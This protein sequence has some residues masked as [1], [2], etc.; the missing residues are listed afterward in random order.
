MICEWDFYRARYNNHALLRIPK[1]VY[2]LVL[3]RVPVALLVLE[4]EEEEDSRMLQGAAKEVL[5]TTLYDV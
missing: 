5:V 1:P 3:L 2:S 4:E